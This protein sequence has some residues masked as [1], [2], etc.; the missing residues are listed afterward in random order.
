MRN[1][2]AVLALTVL[3]PVVLAQ[4]SMPRTHTEI[5]QFVVSSG[6]S[7][8]DSV[9]DEPPELA[10]AQGAIGKHLIE[11]ALDC[12]KV[13]S[14]NPTVLFAFEF[15]TQAHR[16]AAVAG[17]PQWLDATFVDGSAWSIGERG[18][19]FAPGSA[20]KQVRKLLQAEYARR[21]KSGG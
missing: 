3:A 7:V 13:D 2:I 17:S 20:P 15:D 8:C 12:D 6:L 21:A 10:R 5:I 16:D 4:S 19:A 14:K 11:V 18:A 1:P 9:A